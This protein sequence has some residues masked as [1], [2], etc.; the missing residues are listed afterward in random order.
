M[1][2]GLIIFAREPRAGTVKT[3]LARDLRSHRAATDLYAAMLADVLASAAT[4]DDIRLLLFWALKSGAAPA[5]SPLPRLEMFEQQGQGSG[6]TH[7]KRLWQ[8]LFKRL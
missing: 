1:T 3:R 2:R 5:F 8:S 6:R 4:L 7:G